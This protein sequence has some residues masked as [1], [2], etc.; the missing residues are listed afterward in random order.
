M[1]RIV[2]KELVFNDWNRAHIRKHDVTEKE[3][4]ESGRQLI[5]HKQSYEGDM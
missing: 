3:I 1:T 2:I 4:I 5:Y